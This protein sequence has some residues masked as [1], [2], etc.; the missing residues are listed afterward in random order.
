LLQTKYRGTVLAK[1]LL[2][3][4]KDCK[5]ASLISRK[6]V[7]TKGY[8]VWNL[9][10]QRSSLTQLIFDSLQ[11][12]PFRVEVVI[13]YWVHVEV[14]Y[15]FPTITIKMAKMPF[16]PDR[17]SNSTDR[18]YKAHQQIKEGCEHDTP[19]LTHRKLIY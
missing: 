12:Y 9:L 3:H 13:C 11:K 2:H 14:D 17:Y 1:D 8:Y 5:N 7:P 19:S 4:H 6:H 18:Q 15:H 10:M 16:I